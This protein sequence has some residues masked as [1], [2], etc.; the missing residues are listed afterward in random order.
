M[1]FVTVMFGVSLLVSA[2]VA[3]WEPDVNLTNNPATTYMAGPSNHPIVANG[4]SVYVVFTDDRTG[5]YQVYFMRSLDDGTTWDSAVCLSGDSTNIFV[6]ALAV[7]G[8]AV[9][10]AWPTAQAWRSSIGVRPMPA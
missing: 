6:P 1:R 10:V 5:K 2:A 8:A 4:D 7:S 3:Q 9:H